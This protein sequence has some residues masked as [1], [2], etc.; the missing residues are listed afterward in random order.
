MD[1][2]AVGDARF[3]EDTSSID[4][5]RFMGGHHN[6]CQLFNSHQRST[7]NIENETN[8]LYQSLGN[9]K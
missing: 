5:I 3:V 8:D 2:V 4:L 7:L 9:E 1:P 6:D